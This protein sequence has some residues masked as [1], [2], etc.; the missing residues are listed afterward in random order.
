MKVDDIITITVN[1]KDSDFAGEML[2][3]IENNDLSFNDIINVLNSIAEVRYCETDRVI[4]NGHA[5][6]VVR[7]SKI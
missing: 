5:V 7:E 4:A 3:F 6:Q 2:Y 1:D